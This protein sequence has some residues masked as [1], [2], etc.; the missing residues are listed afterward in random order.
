LR[1]NLDAADEVS[2][3][4]KRS[5]DGF[6]AKH[7]IEAPT[8]APYVPVWHPAH[9]TA[10]L[11]YREA[12]VQSVVWC[13]GF[14]AN[15]RWIEVPVFDGRGAPVHGRGVTQE[16]GLYF[17]APTLAA[18]LRSGRFSGV[19]RDAA[20]LADHIAARAVQTP[21]ALNVKAMRS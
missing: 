19:G 11:D 20:Y 15:F 16:E 18:H 4:I 9:E 8:E 10:E 13:I 17:P 21:A 14:R 2:E 6:I 1:A 5:I 12:N 7:G 3:N